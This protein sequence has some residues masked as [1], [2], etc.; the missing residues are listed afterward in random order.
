MRPWSGPIDGCRSTMSAR[1]RR[2]NS[3]EAY[4]PGVLTEESECPLIERL[5]VLVDRCMRTIFEHFE[6]RVPNA[7]CQ[8][9]SKASRGDQVVATERDLRR[10][11]DLFELSF[12]IV[13][14]H[15]GRLAEESV[16]R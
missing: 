12:G 3:R 1:V 7:T 15:G 4:L 5:D 9:S 8:C 14:L 6:L 11:D 10:T 16:K 13:H 2:V